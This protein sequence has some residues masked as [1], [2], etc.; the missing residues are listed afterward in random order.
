MGLSLKLLVDTATDTI[1]G[2][3][4]EGVTKHIDV[5]ATAWC[6]GITAGG[7]ADLELAYV[8]QFDS[9]KD[10]VNMLIVSNLDGGFLTWLRGVKTLVPAHALADSY[11][12]PAAL[13]RNLDNF[14]CR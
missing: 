10:P 8:P 3:Q 6:A 11:T 1:L 9:A 13:P 7:L 4:G 12:G 5:I 14:I 2:V